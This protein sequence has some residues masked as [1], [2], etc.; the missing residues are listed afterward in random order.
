M[1]TRNLATVPVIAACIGVIG[2]SRPSAEEER[3]PVTADQLR[4]IRAVRTKFSDADIS[5]W[6]GEQLLQEM[7]S[8]TGR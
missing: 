7:K 4:Q 2:C 3:F 6:S 1:V 8:S 5:Q